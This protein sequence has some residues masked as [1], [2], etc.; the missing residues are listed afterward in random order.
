MVEGYV[1]INAWRVGI[2]EK[3][4]VMRL[5]YS[6]NLSIC[7]RPCD[8]PRQDAHNHIV[9][10]LPRGPLHAVHIQLLTHTPHQITLG[11]PAMKFDS[12]P[13]PTIRTRIHIRIRPRESPRT[14]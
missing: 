10:S 12:L 8:R 1:S 11:P 7:N 2:C 4:G 3:K 6:K 14:D 13:Q 9:R 5:C